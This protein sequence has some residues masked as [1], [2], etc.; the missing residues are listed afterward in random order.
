MP[1]PVGTDSA[2]RATLNGGLNSTVTDFT[3]QNITTFGN[4]Q[5][6]PYFFQHTLIQPTPYP[7]NNLQGLGVGSLS[8]GGGFNVNQNGQSNKTAYIALS[9]FEVGYTPG[10]H[11][12][13][14]VDLRK[15]ARLGDSVGQSIAIQCWGGHNAAGD[16]G[17]ENHSNNLYPGTVE[18]A[19]TVSGSPGTGATTITITPTAGAATQG[20]GGW[21]LDTNAGRAITGGN[22]TAI[23]GTPPIVTM[24][25]ALASTVIGTLGTAVTPG[26]TQ[27]SI[28][29]TVTPTFTVGTIA[30][31]TTSTL[32]G[33][34]DP[35]EIEW[36]IPS[37]VVG[38]TFTATFRKPHPA[39]AVISVGGRTGYFYSAT[40][41]TYTSS[42]FTGGWTGAI[43]GTLR[44]VWPIISC[45]TT[46][47]QIW[48]SFQGAYQAYPGLWGGVGPSAHTLY[49]GAEITSV[50][51]GG[52]AVS[53]TLTLAPN[54]VAW[55]SADTVTEPL[56]PVM[57]TRG[58]NDV[59]DKYF[60]TMANGATSG[61]PTTTLSGLWTSNDSALAFTNNTPTNLYAAYGVNTFYPPNGINF[62]GPWANG[63][64]F[65]GVSPQ[66][67]VALV[68]ACSYN[69]VACSAAPD[70]SFL[71][72]RAKN[73]DFNVYV[74]PANN[75]LYFNSHIGS[76]NQDTQ[77]TITLTAATS[78][79]LPTFTYPYTN[80]PR[81]LL[82]A[83]TDTTACG[84]VWVTKNAP[85]T[86]IVTVNVK[87]ACTATWDYFVFANV[88]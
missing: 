38:A 43:T 20:E 36:V 29:V 24:N 87:T 63:I 34:A 72:F 27:T 13:F 68:T 86:T 75:A 37:A 57:S 59:V 25:N 6:L 66:G 8:L 10:E 51:N 49:P 44:Q 5:Y 22:T 45:T 50:R 7:W 74:S 79:A 58:G 80:A 53:N 3:S 65:N 52:V 4:S 88:N 61:G 9:A 78:V 48:I 40:A 85:P 18:Y 41:D 62:Q 11:I 56:Y 1:Q 16:E 73:R 12:P 82:Q 30:N 39:S 14:Q 54:A 77:G 55:T 67:A 70:Y 2:G 19:G 32:V 21:L 42:S 28:P 64:F 47:C 23:S 26:A 31:I 35:G 17:C 60:P 15:Y 76:N 71:A 83:T 81:V 33:V 84:A 69:G 46:T